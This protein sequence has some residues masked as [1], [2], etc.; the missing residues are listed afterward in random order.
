MHYTGT[1]EDGKKDLRVCALANNA[2][3]PFHHIWD[4]A[5][6]VLEELSQVAQPLS[7]MLNCSASNAAKTNCK[8]VVPLT[9]KSLRCL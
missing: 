5:I 3:L 2:N 9:K 7:S 8:I 6:E 4:T 1:L